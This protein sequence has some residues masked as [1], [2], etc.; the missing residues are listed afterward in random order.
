MSADEKR[1]RMKLKRTGDFD[2]DD[3]EEDLDAQNGKTVSYNTTPT[4]G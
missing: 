2:A 3:D 4:L 1:M